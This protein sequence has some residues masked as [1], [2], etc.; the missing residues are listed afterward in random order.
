MLHVVLF[1]DV[2][3]CSMKINLGCS[4]T[5][6]TKSNRRG[7]FDSD[8]WRSTIEKYSS[9]PYKV[10]YDGNKTINVILTNRALDRDIIMAYFHALVLGII[11][12]RGQT[13]VT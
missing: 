10:F 2:D 1:P 11:I 8:H 4:L 5:D 6:L 12:D 3:L 9:F 7:T 13:L